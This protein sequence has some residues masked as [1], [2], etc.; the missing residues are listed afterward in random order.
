ML[1]AATAAASELRSVNIFAMVF[2]WSIKEQKKHCV[3]HGQGV[4][5]AVEGCITIWSPIKSVVKCLNMC[6]IIW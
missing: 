3:V 5:K 4:A 2:R 1:A 6:L